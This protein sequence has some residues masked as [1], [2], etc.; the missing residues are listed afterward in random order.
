M[1]TIERYLE[2]FATLKRRKRWTTDT[3]VLRFAAL[4][5]ASADDGHADL[6]QR[7]EGAADEL[8][9]SAGWS[10]PLKSSIRYPIAALILK[11]GKRVSTVHARVGE[12][13]DAFR[14]RRMARGGTYEILAA[15]LLA[16]HHDGGRVP[17]RSI[18]RLQATLKCWNDD[19]PWLTG[20]DDYPMAAL[21]ATRDEGI[22]GAAQRVER[23]YQALRKA[24]FRR[25]NPLQLAT[26]LLTLRDGSA[27]QLTRRFASLVQAFGDRSWSTPTRRYDE[28]AI[29]ALCQAAPRSL[30]AAVLKSMERLREKVRPRPSKDIAFSLATGVVLADQARKQG[31]IADAGDIAAARMAQSVLEAQQAAMVAV[32]SASAGAAAASAAGS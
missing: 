13:R 16:L 8:K 10:S 6:V 25:G 21:H 28:V 3:G 20:K 29:L 7:L 5:L 27:S 14:E 4:T 15:L 1:Q 31:A 2:I 12:V 17:G 24:G 9:A 32:M 19:H 18:D 23:A 30:A 26:H 22:E 11:R